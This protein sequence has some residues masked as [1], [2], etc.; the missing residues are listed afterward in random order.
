MTLSEFRRQ[1]CKRLAACSGDD[2]AF[3]ADCILAE[4]LSCSNSALVVEKQRVLSG[5]QLSAAQ[6]MLSRRLNGEPLQYILGFWEFYG[7]SFAVGSGVLIP[8]P[9]TE[10]LV[11]FALDFLKNKRDAT[12]FD[13]C[14]GSGCVGISVAKAVP[15]AK[16]LMLEKSGQALKYLSRNLVLNRPDNA[17]AVAGDLFDGGEIMSGQKADLILSN[18]PYIKTKDIVSLQREVQ[19]EPFIALD[20]GEDGLEFYRAIAG[21]WLGCL[22][23]NGA[24]A[25]EIG[26]EQGHDAAAIFGQYFNKVAVLKD[27]SGHDRLVTAT[28]KK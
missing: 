24:V 1:L 28:D 18:P 2:A 7:N 5:E 21:L 17:A 16:V 12:V 15:Y 26:E 14:S 27:F 13:L 6:K 8:R 20:G 25:A 22:K 19:H 10:M 23:P 9:E 11:D 4:V 3:E